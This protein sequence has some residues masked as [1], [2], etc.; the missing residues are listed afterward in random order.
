MSLC[1]QRTVQYSVYVYIIYVYRSNTFFPFQSFGGDCGSGGYGEGARCIWKD[2]ENDEN[3]MN[4][5]QA[6]KKKG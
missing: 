1:T 5:K 4:K 2:E 6:N 3:T